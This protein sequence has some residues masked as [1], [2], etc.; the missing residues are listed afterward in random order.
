MDKKNLR[1][2]L[3]VGINRYPFLKKKKLGDLNLKAAVKDAEAIANIL[4]K[5]GKFRIQRLP[6]LPSLPKN[7]DEEGTERFDPNGKVKI[8]ELQKAIINL[9]KPRQKNEIPDVALLFF[10]GHGYVDEKGDIRE[11]FLATSDAHLAENV[12]GISLNWLKRLLQHSP[13]QKQI[14]WLDCCFG[15]EF[16]NFDREANPGTEGKKISRCFI[17]AS[18]SFQTAEEKLDG[19]HGLF[20]DNLLAGLNPENYVKHRC[21]IIVGMR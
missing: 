4:E 2:A 7:Y 14:V 1:Q 6:S 10:A 20:T 17:T 21:F 8:N 3:V 5:Y 18:R 16:L 12:Y 13:V 11:G 19:K 9:F 15:G